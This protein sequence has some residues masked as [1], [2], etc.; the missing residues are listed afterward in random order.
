MATLHDL[1]DKAADVENGYM[2]VPTIEN[3][4]TI[5]GPEF[6]ND[7]G[8]RAIIVRALYES[9]GIGASYCNH[10]ADCMGHL[11]YESCKADPDLWMMTSTRDDVFNATAPETVTGNL[12]SRISHPGSRDTFSTY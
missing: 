6:G 2:T 5:C 3:D 11:G 4:W 1:E 9:K 12:L 10:I 8:K 7:A